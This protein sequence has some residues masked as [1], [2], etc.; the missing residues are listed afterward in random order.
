MIGNLCGGH[1]LKQEA[2]T[3]ITFQDYASF[4]NWDF[5]WAME[6]STKKE[7]YADFI[8]INNELMMLDN[9]CGGPEL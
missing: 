5:S 9:L 2:I 8:C 6:F 3:L 1:E 7:K 4:K